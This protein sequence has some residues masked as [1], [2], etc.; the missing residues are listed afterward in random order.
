[1]AVKT[2]VFSWMVGIGAL[3]YER[4]FSEK[5]SAQ[6]GFLFSPNW[7]TWCS[8]ECSTKG[9]AITPEFRYYLSK[10]PAPRGFYLAPN[11]RYMKIEEENREENGVATLTII[12]PAVNLGI[13]FVLI[14]AL[15]IDIWAGPA[16][17]IK[18]LEE[19]VPDMGISAGELG[20]RI[21]VSIGVVF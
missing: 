17:N 12:S 16:V 13:Q 21:G 5:I 8:E 11:L 19:T 4:V 7:P 6:L 10:K 18:S 15:L 20:I 1:N 3:K 14:N 9:F 2:D